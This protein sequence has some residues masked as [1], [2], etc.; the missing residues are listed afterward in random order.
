MS[1]LRRLGRQGHIDGQFTLLSLVLVLLPQVA[2][3]WNLHLTTLFPLVATQDPARTLLV[4]MILFWAV[5]LALVPLETRSTASGVRWI[6]MRIRH[7]LNL[8]LR[9]VQGLLGSVL[10]VVG[11]L[12]VTRFSPGWQ[13]ASLWLATVLLALIV[14]LPFLID[15]FSGSVVG[16]RAMDVPTPS[17]LA[18]HETTIHWSTA[19]K[20][21]T[22]DLV[23]LAPRDR[24][25]AVAETVFV[26]DSS[27]AAEC[28]ATHGDIPDAPSTAALYTR[29]WAFIAPEL[30]RRLANTTLFTAG[31]GLGSVIAVLAARTGVQR[32]I[33]A[34]GDIVEE[35]NLNRQAFTR[36]HLGQ[37][38]AQATAA[39][40][41]DIQPAATIEVVP[42]YLDAASA[43]EL[44]TR[45]DIILNTIDLDTPAFLDLN[46]VARAAGKP[47]LF[48][49]NPAWMGTVVV[50]TP[51][52]QSLDEFLG[53]TDT[54]NPPSL[55]IITRR[56][57]ERIYAQVPGGLPDTLRT[58]LDA[59]LDG[60]SPIGLAMQQWGAPQLGVTS[61]LTASLAVSALVALV[62]NESVRVA[63]QVITVDAITQRAVVPLP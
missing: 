47:V 19:D 60:G 61:A 51:E 34:D 46:R 37:N 6:S 57:L 36:V 59:S 28:A 4:T 25:V 29:N 39:I 11:G 30:Q 27:A 14:T 7:G 18:T 24:A 45:A 33:L 12:E 9:L 20:V 10:G 42:S 58:L 56:L 50:F 54:S 15:Q 5:T 44:V 26:P 23:G 3:L 53:I 52:A 2:L 55:D 35:S 21:S 62:G 48:P 22:P 38:K 43:A 8:L 17:A 40:L 63:P 31:T 32:F 16:R 41:A 13:A 49:L 1:L